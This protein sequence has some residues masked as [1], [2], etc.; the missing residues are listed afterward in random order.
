MWQHGYISLVH[1]CKPKMWF[2]CVTCCAQ[3]ILCNSGYF[4][5][6]H[7][8][9]QGERSHPWTHSGEQEHLNKGAWVGKRRKPPG[10]F[11]CPSLFSRSN[12]LVMQE[13]REV[14]E[15]KEEWMYY[16][17]IAVLLWALC[18]SQWLVQEV[19]SQGLPEGAK[20]HP[21]VM[22]THS[23]TMKVTGLLVPQI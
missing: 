16:R 12:L 2:C 5:P 9:G 20:S 1:F 22:T 10:L 18:G 6:Q 21:Q 4:S 7:P 13:A 3:D 15:N 23:S 14:V 17:G 11:V 19:T 8:T